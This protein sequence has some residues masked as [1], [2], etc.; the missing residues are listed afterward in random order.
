MKEKLSMIILGS[1]G[2]SIFIAVFVAFCGSVSLGIVLGVISFPFILHGMYT[3]NENGA[4]EA[5]IK[6]EQEAK[7]K[8][9]QE[10]REKRRED[11]FVKVGKVNYKKGNELRHLYDDSVAIIN[12]ML[13]NIYS[14]PLDLKPIYHDPILRGGLASGMA[15]TAAGVYTAIKTDDENRAAKN[16]YNDSQDRRMRIERE[17]YPI[18][19]EFLSTERK[20]MDIL[21]ETLGENC[22]EFIDNYKSSLSKKS[23][24]LITDLCAEHYSKATDENSQLCIKYV[25]DRISHIEVIY[26]GVAWDKSGL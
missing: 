18:Y 4:R 19:K 8:A 16:A 7:Q 15:G 17:A 3:A 6:A 20:M 22:G 23:I 9:E 1:F 5:E 13:R 12:K 25:E 21:K 26:R 2:W 14:R 10:A 11:L 24:N